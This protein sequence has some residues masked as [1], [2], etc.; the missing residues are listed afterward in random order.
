M[1][2]KSDVL[3]KQFYGLLLEQVC[4]FIRTQV[5]PNHLVRLK[6]SLVCTFDKRFSNPC[7]ALQCSVCLINNEISALESCSIY[8]TFTN[9]GSGHRRR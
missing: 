2:R 3:L 6:K 8:K 5:F 4:S 7:I 9:K 1:R